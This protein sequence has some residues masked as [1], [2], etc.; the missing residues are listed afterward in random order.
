VDVKRD[1]VED[2]GSKPAD[3]QED[4]RAEDQALV[5]TKLKEGNGMAWNATVHVQ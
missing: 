2:A 1:R 5:L 3:N 4:Y